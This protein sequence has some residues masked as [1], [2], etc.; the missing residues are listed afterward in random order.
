MKPLWRFLVGIALLPLAHQQFDSTA[1]GSLSCSLLLAGS[2]SRTADVEVVGLRPLWRTHQCSP[3]MQLEAVFQ[4][5]LSSP[6]L[7][8]LGELPFVL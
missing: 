7:L 1:G 5:P 2:C 3:C 8:L 4:S 6:R